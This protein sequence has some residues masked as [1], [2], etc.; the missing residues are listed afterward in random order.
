LGILKDDRFKNKY[1]LQSDATNSDLM[2]I[3]H[4]RNIRCIICNRNT[5]KRFRIGLFGENIITVN[6]K[7]EDNVFFINGF[8]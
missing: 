5:A 8:F 1:I 7:M 6:N 3:L 4:G 2:G